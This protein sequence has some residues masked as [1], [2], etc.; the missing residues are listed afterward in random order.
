MTAPKDSSSEELRILLLRHLEGSL[1]DEEERKVTD[2]LQSDKVAAE[3]E[4]L[5]QIWHTLKTDRTVFCPDVSEIAE[6][7]ATGKDSTGRIESH[8]EECASCRQEAESIR[9][10][11]PAPSIPPEIWNKVSEKLRQRKRSIAEPEVEVSGW[12]SEFLA[13]LS[14][15][16]RHPVAI[17]FFALLALIIVF[18]YSQLPSRS[19]VALSSVS[20]NQDLAATEGSF[21]PSKTKLYSLSPAREKKGSFLLHRERVAF[22]L[23]LKD[24]KTPM[25]QEQIDSLYEALKP[26]KQ[27]QLR[28]DVA[29]PSLV[30]AVVEG[31]AATRSPDLKNLGN[32]LQDKLGL[33]K[34]VLITLISETYEIRVRCELMDA[35]TEKQAREPREALATPRTLNSTVRNLVH[36][37]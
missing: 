16:F 18:L 9:N 33:Q 35:R 23:L 21:P 30:K 32:L 10:F 14:F 19:M 24:F 17:G 2:L 28:Y 8:L 13:A 20:W 27:D 34:V 15:P 11:R 7:L 31:A 12:F 26:D 37:S 4:G 6:F 29:S 25:S 22:L 36:N 1:S 5:R 3:L